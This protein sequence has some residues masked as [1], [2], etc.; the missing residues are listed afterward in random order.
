MIVLSH[1]KSFLCPLW[2]NASISVRSAFRIDRVRVNQNQDASIITLWDVHDD[3]ITENDRRHEQARAYLINGDPTK[4]RAVAESLR[5]MLEAFVRVAYPEVFPPGTLFRP[6]LTACDQRKGTATE[7]LKE[8]DIVELRRLL[9]YANE[10]H[11]DT[12]PA[13]QTATI[14]GQELTNFCEKTLVFARRA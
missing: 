6:F 13:Y 4:E 8:A 3:C 14:S 5:P 7:L 1:S 10:F 2:E 11:H 9:D 12:N